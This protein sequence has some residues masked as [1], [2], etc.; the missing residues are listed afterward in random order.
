MRRVEGFDWLQ[1]DET[2]FSAGNSIGTVIE[3]SKSNKYV[4]I[5]F[6]KTCVETRTLQKEL[7]F[8]IVI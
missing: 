1:F 7:D 8:I 3:V 2:P 4:W 5:N 6:I